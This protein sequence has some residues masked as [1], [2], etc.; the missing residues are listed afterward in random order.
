MLCFLEILFWK[1]LPTQKK[2]VLRSDFRK[3]GGCSES[4]TKTLYQ[5]KF[6]VSERIFK[7][8][9]YCGSCR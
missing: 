6:L 1:F 9:C 7:F 4:V 8:V 5:N 3:K 2:S